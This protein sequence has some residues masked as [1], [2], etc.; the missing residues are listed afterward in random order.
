LPIYYG[1]L[2]W[3]L[4]HAPCLICL[5]NMPLLDDIL[6]TWLNIP[7]PTPLVDLTWIWPPFWI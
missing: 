6:S 4:G 3:L 2:L 1:I 7:T 5:P